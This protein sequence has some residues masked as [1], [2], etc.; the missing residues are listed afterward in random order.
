MVAQT[1]SHLTPL[2]MAAQGDHYD[3]ARLLILKKAPIDD[4]TVVR[5]KEICGWG[6]W[7]WVF[8]VWIFREWV[9]WGGGGYLRVDR[10]FGIV[11][12]L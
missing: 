7:V 4:V 10:F 11:K 6:F 3:C 2:H 9:F 8:W 1:K 12:I 5:G